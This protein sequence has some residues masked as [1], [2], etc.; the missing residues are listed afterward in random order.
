MPGTHAPPTSSA[1]IQELYNLAKSY[2]AAPLQQRCA[3]MLVGI[4]TSGGPQG[5]IEALFADFTRLHPE[6][7]DALIPKL[8]SCRR[9]VKAAPEWD[10]QM[11]QIVDGAEAG[12][13]EAHRAWAGLVLAKLS[14]AGFNSP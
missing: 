7:A 12:S 9:K 3:D 5:L 1:D 4:W 10:A 2:L 6:L 14:R 13:D 11:A 8:V